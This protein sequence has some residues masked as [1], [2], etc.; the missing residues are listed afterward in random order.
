MAQLPITFPVPREVRPNLARF[1]I[2][3]LF[4][5]LRDLKRVHFMSVDKPR[6]DV[7][8]SGNI[9]S[10][11]I[12]QNAKK[13]P[14]FPNML[15]FFDVELPV[16]EMYAP[17]ITIR[18]VD[19]RSF[20]RYTLVGTHQITSIH[21]YSHRPMPKDAF[22]A[23]VKANQSQ[24]ILPSDK[25]TNGSGTSSQHEEQ[26]IMTMEGTRLHKNNSST[27]DNL[28]LYGAACVGR[29]Y[30]LNIEEDSGKSEI[31]QEHFLVTISFFYDMIRVGNLSLFSLFS[32]V[33][34]LLL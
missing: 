28:T 23:A 30:V 29:A 26:L 16:E 13:N 24:I 6:I 4:W 11:S 20:G 9:L 8:C 5:G 3:V 27:C 7:E 18:C 33:F 31:T 34:A 17:P 32:S 10:S 19:C 12:I 22:N 25:Q 21:K 15:K 2:E 1:R 14:N